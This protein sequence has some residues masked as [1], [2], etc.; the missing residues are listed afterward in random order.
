[1]INGSIDF[2]Y[3]DLGEFIISTLLDLAVDFDYS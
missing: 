3:Y 1:M 2:F